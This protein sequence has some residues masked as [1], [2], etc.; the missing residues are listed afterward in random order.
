MIQ[1]A[2]RNG[3][4]VMPCSSRGEGADIAD[5]CV[6]INAGTVRETRHRAG[7]QPFPAR[8]RPSW[9]RGRSSPAGRASRG[10]ASEARQHSGKAVPICAGVPVMLLYG[11]RTS[12]AMRQSD[13]VIEVAEYRRLHPFRERST[14]RG[15]SGVKLCRGSY[16]KTAMP[17][18]S[19]PF[20]QDPTA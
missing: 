12:R 7:R 10:P 13:Y 11:R 15:C 6:G 9:A 20:S 1:L 18:R 4:A 14:G 19:V 16:L 17:S 5:Y 2:Y 3:Y 8:S